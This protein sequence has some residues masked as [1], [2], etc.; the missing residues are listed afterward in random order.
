[1]NKFIIL[2]E[3]RE[4]ILNLHKSRTSELYLNESGGQNVKPLINEI[5]SQTIRDYHNT[6]DNNNKPD[7]AKLVGAARREGGVCQFCMSYKSGDAWTMENEETNCSQK[8]VFNINDNNLYF[9]DKIVTGYDYQLANGDP[10]WKTKIS[11]FCKGQ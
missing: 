1:M 4:R 6:V 10:N 9:R 7:S 5:V 11:K 3:E 8:F 2:E